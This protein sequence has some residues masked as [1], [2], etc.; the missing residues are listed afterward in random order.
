MVSANFFRMKIELALLSLVLAGG[1]LAGGAGCAG[2]EVVTLNVSAAASLTDALKE[3][4]VLYAKKKANV[5]ITPNFASSGILQKQIEQGA[6]SDV[7]ISAAASQMDALQ[8]QG[9]LLNDTRKDLLNNRVVLVVP[10]DNRLRIASF[11]D[12]TG[13]GVKK[14]AM[15]D[16]KSVPAGTYGQQAFDELGISAQVQSKLVLAS[17]VRQVLS[18]VETGNVDAGVVYSSDAKT[19]A[20]VKVVASA[21]DAVNARVV[22]PAAVIKA[23]Q[24]A[25]DARDYVSF[26]LGDGARTVFEKYGFSMAKQQNP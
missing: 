9:L 1:L 14:I 24:D 8:K 11:K 16:P 23:T 25:G 4:N 20:R 19:S 7:F 15:G 5:T 10:G 26:L 18:Y 12:L 13:D 22:Y 17:D 3:I 6:P 2:K 21:P